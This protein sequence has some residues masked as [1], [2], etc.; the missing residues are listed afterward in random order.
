MTTLSIIL[1]DSLAKESQEA[2]SRLGISRT[3]FIRQAIAHELKNFQ[4]QL[5]QKAIVGSISAMKN[6]KTYLKEAE[7][8]TE[9]LNAN[10]PDEG[11]NWWSKKS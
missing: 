3:Q 11:E 2:A 4:S 1:P 5:E 7:K 8:I 6:S 9:E 10:L